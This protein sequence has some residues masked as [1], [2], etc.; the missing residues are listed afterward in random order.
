M[1]AEEPSLLK[2]ISQL[3][4]ATG[5]AE[6]GLSSVIF[7]GKMGS[8][9]DTEGVLSM[10]RT[11]VEHEVNS[12]DSNVTGLLMG[13]GTSVMHFIEGPSYAIL[14]IVSKLAEHEQF[15]E[16]SQSTIRQSGRIV[17]CVEDRPSRFFPEW[18]SCVMPEKKGA[19]AEDLNAES[20]KDTVSELSSSL[21]EMGQRLTGEKGPVEMSTY[22]ELLPSKSLLLAL[23]GCELFFTVDDYVALLGDSYHTSLESEYAWPLTRLVNY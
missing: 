20:C 1:N 12:E 21:S 11:V 3:R 6:G 2:H 5:I 19:L 9:A 7:C 17:Y 18:Y 4:G 22:A 10:H 15:V 13:Q 16:S 14:R 23:A 8:E